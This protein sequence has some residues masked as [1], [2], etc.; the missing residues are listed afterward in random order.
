MSNHED[1]SGLQ[2]IGLWVIFVSVGCLPVV[3]ATSLIGVVV[4]VVMTSMGNSMQRKVR[5]QRAEI[6]RLEAEVRKSRQSSTDN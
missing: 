2:G 4:G 1:G 5:E 3:G 6:E